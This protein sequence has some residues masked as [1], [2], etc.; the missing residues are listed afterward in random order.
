MTGTFH[1]EM[2]YQIL[3]KMSIGHNNLLAFFSHLKFEPIWCPD[4]VSNS[5]KSSMQREIVSNNLK[6]NHRFKQAS[7]NNKQQKNKIKQQ[8][9][10]VSNRSK[11]QREKQCEHL[12]F[13]LSTNLITSKKEFWGVKLFYLYRIKFLWYLFFI[14][15][16]GTEQLT[17]ASFPMIKIAF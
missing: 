16:L 12:K 5:P 13:K 14:R 10:N 3:L 6:I 7:L 8:Q 4:N 2:C 15:L 17:N 9:Q 11:K 1:D